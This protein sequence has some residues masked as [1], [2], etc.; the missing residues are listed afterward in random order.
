MLTVRVICIGKLKE[1]YWT[2]AC[3]EYQKRLQPYCKFE[4]VELPEYRLPAHP[5]E[6]QIEIGMKK[7]GEQM[8]SCC[9]GGYRIAMCI[10]GK[11]LDSVQLSKKI[12]EIA[13]GGQSELSI[14]IGGSYGLSDEVKRAANFRLSMSPMTFPHQMA[15][16]MVLEQLYRAFQI[17]SNGKYHK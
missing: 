11:Q 8:L 15:R 13:L 7:E 16:V 10:E 5:S 14:L 6:A 4:L 1:R 3:R 2:E 9:P 12:E 17:Q